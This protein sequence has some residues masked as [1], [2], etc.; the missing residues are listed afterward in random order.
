MK[1]EKR[2]FRKLENSLL[3][4]NCCPTGQRSASGSVPSEGVKM[5]KLNKLI[6]RRTKITTIVEW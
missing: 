2:I 6:V 4:A 5:F 3:F 1:P